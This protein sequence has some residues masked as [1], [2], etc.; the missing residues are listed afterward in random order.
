MEQIVE[1]KAQVEATVA[2]E[3]QIIELSLN[4]LPNV[5]GGAVAAK[6]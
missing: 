5:G 4:L 3:E 2:A 6:L 1:M